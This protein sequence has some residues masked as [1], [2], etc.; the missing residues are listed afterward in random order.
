MHKQ[1]FIGSYRF[2]QNYQILRITYQEFIKKN[3]THPWKEENQIRM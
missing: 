2:M 1:K 3:K